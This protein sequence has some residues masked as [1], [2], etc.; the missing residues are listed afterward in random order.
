[1]SEFEVTK[2]E[3]SEVVE[4]LS[5][6]KGRQTE[7]ITVYIPAGYDVNAVQR[8]LEAEKS[9]AKNIKSTATRKNVGE[10]LDKIVRYLKELKQTPEKGLAIFCGN[11][12][13]DE[14]QS[15]IEIWM[16][17]TPQEINTRLYRCDQE[18]VL[19]PL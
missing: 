12:S 6:I 17:E 7:L 3:L 8:Q 4:K 14:G 1:M 2:Q 13:E 18:I 16:I 5:N 9:T 10:A 11:V 19:E 15:E